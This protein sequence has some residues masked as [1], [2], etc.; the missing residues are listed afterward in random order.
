MEKC[1]KSVIDISD[2]EVEAIKVLKNF[3]TENER[4]FS[5]HHLDPL[6]R[7]QFIEVILNELSKSDC[8]RRTEFESVG[9]STLRILSRDKHTLGLL[10][11][12]KACETL[13]KLSGL[14]VN[15]GDEVKPFVR[16][17][18]EERFSEKQENGNLRKTPDTENQNNAQ[19]STEG[20]KKEAKNGAH[21][22]VANSHEFSNTTA[23][24]LP[25]MKAR[26]SV[27][28]EALKCLCNAVFQSPLARN[29]CFKNNLTE[30]VIKRLKFFGKEDVPADVK[31]FDMRLLFLLT[32]LGTQERSVAVKCG[33]LC[34]LTHALDNCVPGRD[35]REMT[36]CR[37]P[38]WAKSDNGE[39]DTELSVLERYF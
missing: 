23:L 38:D 14:F 36:H 15:F 2:N 19:Y 7:K 34:V 31:F 33:G 4:V 28:V 22:T 11:S 5:F 32:A 20:R 13:I 9:L 30:V 29:H 16:K 27:V 24:D 12:E 21:A 3:C 17:E 10:V 18:N 6:F 26:E 8:R 1:L 35:E 25:S 37:G 39:A